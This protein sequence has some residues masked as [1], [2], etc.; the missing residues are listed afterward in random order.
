MNERF[1]IEQRYGCIAVVDTTIRNKEE[2]PGLYAETTGVL[3]YK[4]GNFVSKGTCDKCS[5]AMLPHWELPENLI[6]AATEEA[7]RLNR[8]AKHNHPRDLAERRMEAEDM[9]QEQEAGDHQAELESY[10]G[11]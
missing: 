6:Q 1:V 4:V 3:W 10:H 11:E 5:Q 2:E 7:A 9:K 8:E